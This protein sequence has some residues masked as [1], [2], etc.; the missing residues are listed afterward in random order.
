MLN[1]ELHD[2]AEALVAAIQQLDVYDVFTQTRAEFQGDP[3]LRAIRKHFNERSTELQNKQST[4]GLSQEEINEL[5]ALQSN[6]NTHPVT[7]RY[8]QARQ[9]LVV[10]LQEYNSRLS[11]ELGFDFA[12]AAARQSCC[13]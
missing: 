9:R 5:R 7:T 8:L 1:T 13:G 2:A 6:V 4:G 10:S 12:S 11:Q 3:V